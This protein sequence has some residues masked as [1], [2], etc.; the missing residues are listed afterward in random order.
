MLSAIFPSLNLRSSALS[1]Q[2]FR[3]SI[4]SVFFSAFGPMSTTR[5]LFSHELIITPTNI[6][7]FINFVN[8]CKVIQKTIIIYI[9]LTKVNFNIPLN[10]QWIKLEVDM[11]ITH[12]LPRIILNA[13]ITTNFAKD[14]KKGCSQLEITT[15]LLFFYKVHWNRNKTG[16]I[17]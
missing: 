14:F 3:K 5:K 15:M 9:F 4:A 12:I 10:G 1:P 7:S 13:Y 2:N 8:P 17:K 6:G 11:P 16:N